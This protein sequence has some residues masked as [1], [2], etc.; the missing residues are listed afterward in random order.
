MADGFL[1]VV[2]VVVVVAEE[3]HQCMERAGW[4]VAPIIHPTD[5]RL[6]DIMPTILMLE[7]QHHH[8]AHPS[9]IM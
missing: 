2:I 7:E 3:W 9:R 1:T 5:N 4:V 8:T 6:Q